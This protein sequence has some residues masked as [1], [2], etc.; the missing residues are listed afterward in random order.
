MS[1]SIDAV[2]QLGFDEFGNV[3]LLWG[4]RR[5]NNNNL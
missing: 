5:V 2:E 4:K 1:Q 3:T